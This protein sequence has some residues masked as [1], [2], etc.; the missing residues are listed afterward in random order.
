[1][2]FLKHQKIYLN[3]NKK[4]ISYNNKKIKIILAINLKAIKSLI[5]F[6]RVKMHKKI[7]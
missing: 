7:M 2:Q 5:K 6:K 3:K 4:K 1:M